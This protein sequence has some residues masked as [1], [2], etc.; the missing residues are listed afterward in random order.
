MDTSSVGS[1]DDYFV[2]PVSPQPAPRE[3]EQESE[4]AQAPEPADESGRNIDLF[5]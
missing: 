4:A 5:A 2:P 1:V 3:L